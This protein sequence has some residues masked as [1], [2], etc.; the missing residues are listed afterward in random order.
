MN[1]DFMS[2]QE[3]LHSQIAKKLGLTTK[4]PKELF[5][6]LLKSVKRIGINE[7]IKY[8]ENE[9]DFF[10]APASTRFHGNYKGALV[11]HSLNVYTLLAIKNNQYHLGL[12]DENV[13]LS[14][15]LHDVCKTNFY[16]LEAKNKKIYSDTGKLHDQLGNFYWE[17]RLGYG[18]EDKFPLGHGEKSMSIVSDFIKLEDVEK[19]LIRWH[20]GP[21]SSRGDYDFNNAC[22]WNPA[23]AAIYTADFESS[24]L[25]EETR[26]YIE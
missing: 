26:E 1:R 12:S 6:G 17:S 21:F 22:D 2:E 20:M 24:V 15:L 18:V 11:Q 16:I 4:D 10:E 5:V 9:T 13:I 7:L 3:R 25:F 23:I 8:L 19:M 14:A